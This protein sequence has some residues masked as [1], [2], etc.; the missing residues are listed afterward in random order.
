MFFGFETKEFKD[1]LKKASLAEIKYQVN[2]CEELLKAIGDGLIS[3]NK[4][5]ENYLST[6]IRNCKQELKRR[7]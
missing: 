1:R 7:K 4:D 3:P 5:I 2:W 6:F